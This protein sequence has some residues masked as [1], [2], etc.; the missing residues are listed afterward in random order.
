MGFRGVRARGGTDD[1]WGS[2]A[3]IGTLMH[4]R[5][6]RKLVHWVRQRGDL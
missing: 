3:S 6:G 4:D 2:P 1:F 5:G